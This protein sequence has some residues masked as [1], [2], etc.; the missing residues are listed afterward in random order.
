MHLDS[1]TP[2][3][4]K[5]SHLLFAKQTKG[6]HSKY[7]IQ[8]YEKLPE[9][10]YFSKLKKKKNWHFLITPSPVGILTLS[11]NI[12]QHQNLRHP[13]TP[14]KHSDV[15]YGWPLRSQS[16]QKQKRFVWVSILLGDIQIWLKHSLLNI[17]EVLMTE[18]EFTCQ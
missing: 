10:W 6:I 13:S 3:V 15:F 1:E 16:A 5:A 11:S 2:F 18:N 4:K 12:L 8:K 9:V 7:Y 14:L 17:Q